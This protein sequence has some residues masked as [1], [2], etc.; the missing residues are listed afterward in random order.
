[1]FFFS[2]IFIDS[3]FTPTQN[4]PKEHL[5]PLA[6]ISNAFDIMKDQ[7][8]MSEIQEPIILKDDKIDFT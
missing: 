4:L 8:V 3:K 6:G 1:M 2:M 5:I 7:L